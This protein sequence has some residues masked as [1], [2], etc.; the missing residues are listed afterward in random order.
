MS[1]SH[2][3]SY[4]E[5]FNCVFSTV[6]LPLL[7]TNQIKATFHPLFVY[8]SIPSSQR[9]PCFSAQTSPLRTALSSGWSEVSPPQAPSISEGARKRGEAKSG[10]VG[11]ARTSDVYVTQLLFSTC[12]LASSL[13]TSLQDRSVLE[14]ARWPS[15]LSRWPTLVKRRSFLSRSCS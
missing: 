3:C 4:Q 6:P 13:W 2:V 8:L 10:R 15:L 11:G 9:S 7:R 5:P 1:F 12:S 14:P